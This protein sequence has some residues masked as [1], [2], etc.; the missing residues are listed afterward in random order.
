MHRQTEQLQ[1]TKSAKKDA[2]TLIDAYLFVFD[3]LGRPGQCAKNFIRHFCVDGGNGAST[4]ADSAW[5]ALS[6]VLQS[7]NAQAE[8]TAY[9]A[10]AFEAGKYQLG[11]L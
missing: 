11:T 3:R 6:T 9:G 8:F 4:S 5:R 10:G 2:S 7:G 1:E